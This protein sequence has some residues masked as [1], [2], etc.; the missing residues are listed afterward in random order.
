MWRL[1]LFCPSHHQ[2]LSKTWAIRVFGDP[3]NYDDCL[4]RN[5]RL[6]LY[7]T[8][9]MWWGSLFLSRV[10]LVEH[11]MQLDILAHR[12]CSLAHL[13]HS[14][15]LGCWWCRARQA[16]VQS[17]RRRGQP[18]AG[19]A[20][21]TALSHCPLLFRLLTQDFLFFVSSLGSV[22]QAL[23]STGIQGGAL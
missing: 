15:D 8:F 21:S 2:G 1:T 4:K 23:G 19:W 16:R 9:Q 3:H 14:D 20:G 6:M 13:A 18:W 22:D 5:G 11:G 7:L 17:Q 12:Y 10:M